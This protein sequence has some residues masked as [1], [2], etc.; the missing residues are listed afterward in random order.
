MAARSAIR[1]TE[2]IHRQGC[3]SNLA[4]NLGWSMRVG[5][6]AEVV[7]MDGGGEEVGGWRVSGRYLKFSRPPASDGRSSWAQQNHVIRRRFRLP[8]CAAGLSEIRV[9]C[10]SG[11]IERARLLG[12]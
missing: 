1:Y 12:K 6:L 8:L 5:V 4:T 3:E 2:V 11:M 7:V 9:S 10:L